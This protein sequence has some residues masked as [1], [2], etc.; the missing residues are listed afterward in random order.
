LFTKFISSYQIA[1][2]SIDTKKKDRLEELVQ[3]YNTMIR[4][5]PESLFLEDLDKKMEKVNFDIGL[6]NQTKAQ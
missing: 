2:N 6:I 5:Y 3:Q 1:V 4:Y